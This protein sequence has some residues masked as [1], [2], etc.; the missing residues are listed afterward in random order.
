MAAIFFLCVLLCHGLQPQ[1]RSPRLRSAAA[2]FC[3]SLSPT[4]VQRASKQEL[5]A[6]ALPARTLPDNNKPNK[7]QR[8]HTKIQTCKR[9]CSRERRPDKTPSTCTRNIQ[10]GDRVAPPPRR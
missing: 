9:A 7:I 4:N 6:G 8:N 1:Q 10:T 2:K 3:S 5:R